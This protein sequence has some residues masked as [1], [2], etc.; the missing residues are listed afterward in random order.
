MKTSASKWGLSLV[1][2]SILLLGQVV[3]AIPVLAQGTVVIP[4]AIP[5]QRDDPQIAV[6]A[7]AALAFAIVLA[8]LALGVLWWLRQRQSNRWTTW[9]GHVSARIQ[10]VSSAR[11]APHTSIHVVDWQGRRYVLAVHPGG[12]TQ[13]DPACT[14]TTES[15]KDSSES[16]R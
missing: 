13:M 15:L 7:G 10:V 4:Q 3:T 16:L 12:V 5:V 11:I 14:L 1:P 6:T 2:A 8:A 9:G